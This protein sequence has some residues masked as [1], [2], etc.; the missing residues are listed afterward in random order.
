MGFAV[1]EAA[2]GDP[3]STAKPPGEP[4][5][6]SSGALV[7]NRVALAVAGVGVLLYL[8]Y[9]H[10]WLIVPLAFVGLPVLGYYGVRLRQS[11]ARIVCWVAFGAILATAAVLIWLVMHISI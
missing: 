5:E 3:D 2:V 4:A 9:T 7:S 1:Q 11:W 8:L 10:I 6:P